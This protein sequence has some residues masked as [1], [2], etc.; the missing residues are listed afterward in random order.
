MNKSE[1]EEFFGPKDRMSIGPRLIIGLVVVVLIIAS[2]FFGNNYYK[3]KLKTQ[4]SATIVNIPQEQI[5]A[6]WK[7]Y[8]NQKYKLSFKYPK[9]WTSTEQVAKNTLLS[10]VFVKTVTGSV[11]KSNFFRAT[12]FSG[13]DKL[14]S[15]GLKPASLKDYLDKYSLIKD[16]LYKNVAPVKI[17]N[18]NGYKVEMGPNQ[19]GDGVAYF[20]QISNG[21]ILTFRFFTNSLTES[22]IISLISTVKMTAVLT[23]IQTK[24]FSNKDLKFEFLYPKTWQ[25]VLMSEITQD[26]ASGGRGK[27][28]SSLYKSG[29]TKSIYYDPDSFFGF[30]TYSIDY[31]SAPY[32]AVGPKKVDLSWT[33]EQF[34]QNLRP[35]FDVLG[36]QKLGKNGILVL[37]YA[38]YECNPIF[39]ANVYI[40]TTNVNYPNLL[41]SLN[42]SNVVLDQ[43]VR[44]YIA[45]Q[46][47]AGKSTC[48]TKKP[49]QLIADKILAGTYS[50]KMKTQ[51]EIAQQI[52]D[53]FKNLN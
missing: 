31:N 22:E 51:L 18:M 5:V 52:A 27:A 49:F 42:M 29:S 50:T 24:T 53:S 34:V 44:D 36:Y 8:L 32:A 17:G 48:D 43:T 4:A 19:S 2:F 3:N 39:N 40:P 30:K 38:T 33:K 21:Q 25:D 23:Q 35:S 45:I 6:S 37:D 7:T 1:Q 11:D 20:T 41:I 28:Y 9:E 47:K 46:A 16:P 10:V 26:T 15:N 13:L 12:I 14:D